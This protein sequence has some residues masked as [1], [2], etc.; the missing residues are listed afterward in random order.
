MLRLSDGLKMH[1]VP[2]ETPTC[3]DYVHL[4]RLTQLTSNN[5]NNGNDNSNNS[6]VNI[7]TKSL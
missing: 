6:T 3:C 1:N 7:Q 5:N 4:L 2:R